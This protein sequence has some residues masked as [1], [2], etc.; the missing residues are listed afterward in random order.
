MSH[1]PKY[2][3]ERYRDYLRL[4]ADMQLNP[5]LRAKEDISDVVQRSLLQ[6]HQ[7][8][9]GFRGST[10]AELRGWL[11]AILTNNLANLAKY[12]AAQ[13]RDIRREI[14]IDQQLQRSAGR[15]AAQLPVDNETPSEHLVHQERAEQLA[16][17]MTALLEDE[18][19]AVVL[20]YIHGWRVADIA[21]RLGRSP[22]AVAGLLARALKK[23]RVLLE[24]PLSES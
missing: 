4:L 13:K 19:T 20:K 3:L 10:E 17:A 2:D 5:R 14:S 6:A 1:E 24:E 16:D 23:L 15:L 11:K 18:R 22:E 21:V 8:I 7:A 9:H 12:H